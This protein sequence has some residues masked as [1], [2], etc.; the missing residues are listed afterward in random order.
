MTAFFSSAAPYQ[1]ENDAA[2]I[3]SSFLSERDGF[4]IL[5][6]ARPDGDTVGSAYAL[7]AAL[8]EAGKRAFLFP[9]PTGGEQFRRFY[10]RFAVSPPPEDLTV[11]AVDVADPKLLPPE[12]APYGE[13]AALVIDHHVK[14]RF[15]SGIHAVDPTAAAAAEIVRDI[16]AL[17]GL[18]LSR[19]S[20]EGIYLG[21]MT[22]TG[23]FKFS[24]VSPRT[25]RVASDA[26]EAG[27]DAASLARE[28]FIKSSPARMALEA[29]LIAGFVRRAE[30]RIILAPLSAG[31]EASFGAN[32]D[33]TAG[34][35]SLTV[36]P[37]GCEIGILLREV[38]EGIKVSIRTDLYADAAAIAS[39][40]GG[41]GHVRA[42]GCT[43]TGKTM[44]EA[45]KLMENEALKRL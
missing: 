35:A 18:P 17:L 20:A 39:A 41:G 34:L 4:L 24:N 22:D 7:C 19:E 8:R 43:L 32:E 33:D 28:F 29:Y 38:P 42:A 13:K 11:V 5:T 12:A 31:A 14:N 21:V 9:D 6:H 27:A 37:E 3:A 1:R 2:V 45:L 15:P 30:G 40:F 36:K 44:D 10:A 26:M 23:C 16:I 25:H